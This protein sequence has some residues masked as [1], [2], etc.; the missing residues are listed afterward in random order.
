MSN[1]DRKLQLGLIIVP[2]SSYCFARQA[3]SHRQSQAPARADQ[4]SDSCI[5]ARLKLAF[6]PQIQGPSLHL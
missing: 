4:V 1:L 2:Q 5:Q 3:Q 6:R